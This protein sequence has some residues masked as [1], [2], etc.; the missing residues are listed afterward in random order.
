MTCSLTFVVGPPGTGKT[1]VARK[2]GELFKKHGLLPSDNVIVTSGTNLQGQYVGET[3]TK[4]IKAMQQARGGILLIDEA[5]GLN[6]TKGNWGYATEAVDTL[7]GQI[8]EEEFKGN[9]IVIMAGYA[10][11]IDDMFASVNP[12]L[13]SRYDKK[14]VKFPPWSGEQAARATIAEIEKDG[15][16]ITSAAQEELIKCYSEMAKDASW[17]SARDVFENILPAMYSK[18]AARM[19]KMAHRE[20]GNS[21][22]EVSSVP[23]VVVPTYEVIDVTE[24]FE[25]V[26]GSRVLEIDTQDGLTSALEA[27]DK[28]VV[29]DFYAQW[30]GPC[31]KFS[32]QFA[33]MKQEFKTVS[34]YRVDVDKNTEASEKYEI[35]SIPTLLLFVN[36]SMLKKIVG[37]NER[38]LKKCVSDFLKVHTFW[39]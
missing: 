39:F 13:R 30:C 25:G 11:Q 32:P 29:V 16:S 23:E 33:A 22:Q 35:Q 14:R 3:K 26:L 20:G 12:G 10:G 31:K 17:A 2:F 27:P 15:K 6:P 8:T 5:Y 24:A 4:V 7:V 36:G 34:F 28:L 19:V 38:T 1:T 21:V 18:L 37:A 9:L